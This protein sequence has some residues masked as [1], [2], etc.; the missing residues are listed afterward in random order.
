MA[1]NDTQKFKGG[2]TIIQEIHICNE[3]FCVARGGKFKGAYFIRKLIQIHE[4]EKK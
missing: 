3:N 2:M 4:N 1:R